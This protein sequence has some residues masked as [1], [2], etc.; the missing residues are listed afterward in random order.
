MPACV[1]HGGEKLL[2]SDQSVT[3]EG[4]SMQSDQGKEE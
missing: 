4:N 1:W 3:L 2:T